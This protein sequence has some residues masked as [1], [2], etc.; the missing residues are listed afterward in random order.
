MRCGGSPTPDD[1]DRM[2]SARVSRWL[3]APWSTARLKRRMVLWEIRSYPDA[4]RRERDRVLARAE[5]RNSYG[6][7]WRWRAPVSAGAVPA[8]RAGPGCT[9]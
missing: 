3:L 9:C 5:M 8:W 2:D 6:W 1:L 4:L 7:A